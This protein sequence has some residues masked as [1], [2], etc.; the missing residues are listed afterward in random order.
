MRRTV[1]VPEQLA[2][3][4]PSACVTVAEH[5]RHHGIAPAGYPFA[6][7]HP[8]PDGAVE[9]EAGFPVAAPIPG[10]EAIEPS[11]LPAGP[12]LAVRHTDPHEKLAE[13]YHT[14]DD[15]LDSEHATATGDSWEVYHDLPTCDHVGIRIEIIQPI[16]FT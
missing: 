8:L 5:L 3:W 4:V 2:D 15:W 6:R 1:L 10:C 12:V 13:T 14:V 9:A 16:S 7:W 11:T